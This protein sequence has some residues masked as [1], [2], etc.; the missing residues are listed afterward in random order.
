LMERWGDTKVLSL[1][2]FSPGVGCVPFSFVS[3]CGLLTLHTPC[4]HMG[5]H[6]RSHKVSFPL[7]LR[8][9]CSPT[10]PSTVN[11]PL[12]PAPPFSNSSQTSPS[13]L[14]G[15]HG[16]PPLRRKL[17]IAKRRRRLKIRRRYSPSSPCIS[18][19]KHVHVVQLS[20]ASLDLY[21]A[22]EGRFVVF[23]LVFVGSSP[24][25]LVPSMWLRSQPYPTDGSPCCSQS[26]VTRRVRFASRH[27]SGPSLAPNS[28]FDLAEKVECGSH[29]SSSSTSLRLLDR[30]FS[31][32]V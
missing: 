7:F 12:L 20:S 11:S 22:V 21:G 27:R 24:L 9:P 17:E 25:L 14:T 18:W 32:L 2:G 13:A 5:A 30:C 16:C 15:R 3:F 4:R 31:H 23:F 19:N 6:E 28:V 10:H 8:S 1:T 29:C 26:S